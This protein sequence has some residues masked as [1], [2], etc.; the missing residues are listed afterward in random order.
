MIAPQF[1]LCKF[2]HKLINLLPA[3]SKRVDG[4]CYLPQVLRGEL[5]DEVRMLVDLLEELLLLVHFLY[6]LYIAFVW[7]SLVKFYNQKDLFRELWT[8]I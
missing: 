7:R 2:N 4:R 5:I 6:F 3:D 1:T 8:V